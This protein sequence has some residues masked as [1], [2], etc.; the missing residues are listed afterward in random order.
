MEAL[1]PFSRVWKCF[2]FS[3]SNCVYYQPKPPPFDVNGVH[4]VRHLTGVGEVCFETKGTSPRIRRESWIVFD[5]R[6]KGERGRGK[7]RQCSEH[8]FYTSSYLFLSFFLG[9][10][11]RPTQMH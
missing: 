2:F 5:K 1:I 3:N 9:N 4:G 8:F 11:A 10:A 7:E 6:S